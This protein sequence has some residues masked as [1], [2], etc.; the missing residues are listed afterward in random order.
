MTTETNSHPSNLVLCV[1]ATLLC[2]NSLLETL[3][4]RSLL[5]EMLLQRSPL[6][7]MPGSPW[8]LARKCRPD[9]YYTVCAF[10]LHSLDL[11]PSAIHTHRQT[12]LLTPDS[13][14]GNQ[15]STP[16]SDTFSSWKVI[17]HA[18]S[19]CALIVT[20]V[21]CA[22]A[23]YLCTEDWLPVWSFQFTESTTS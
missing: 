11:V 3:L 14:F 6:A 18:S 16:F 8:T 21:S 2:R 10:T 13:G 7:W 12:S 4:P 1:N 17:P 15:F 20:L 9:R 22:C 23:L 5:L 19:F